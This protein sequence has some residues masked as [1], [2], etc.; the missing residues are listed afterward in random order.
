MSCWRFAA[1]GSVMCLC[2]GVAVSAAAQQGEGERIGEKVDQAIGRLREEGKDLAGR[3]REG[4]EEARATVDRM[5]EVGRVYARL[6]WDKALQNASISVDVGKDGL[7]TLRGTVP[8]EEAKT[9]ASQLAGDTVGVK[10]VA[11]DLKVEPAPAR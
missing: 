2:L 3:V 5:S 7:A 4:F 10:R 11:N 6:H 9:K 1:V 8:N